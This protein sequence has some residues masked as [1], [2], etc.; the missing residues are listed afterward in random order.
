MDVPGFNAMLESLN[1]APVGGAVE[2][3]LPRLTVLAIEGAGHPGSD[4]FRQGI[5]DLW[6]VAYAVQQL[7]RT[8]WTPPG[9]EPYEMPP[10]EVAFESAVRDCPW[11]MFFPQPDFVTT[12]VL[13]RVKADLEAKDKAVEGTVFLAVHEPERVVQTMHLGYP[14]GLPASVAVV[15]RYAEEHGLTL[16]PR[17]HEVFIDDPIRIGFETARDLIRYTVVGSPGAS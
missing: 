1:E 3:D 11:R 8:D 16:A 6:R 2:Q 10:T 7:P 17:Q 12:E 9:F 13:D 14:T 4:A 15:E 5:R